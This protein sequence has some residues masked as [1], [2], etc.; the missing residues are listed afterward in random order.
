MPALFRI[1]RLG[2]KISLGK[3]LYGGDPLKRVSPI[4]RFSPK[5]RGPPAK[6]AHRLFLR[7]VSSMSGNKI[8]EPLNN[9]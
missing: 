4:E 7:E 9:P 2:G 3:T 5:E 1:A 8:K 6:K